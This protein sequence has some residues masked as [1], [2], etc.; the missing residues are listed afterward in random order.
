MY[1]HQLSYTL[2]ATSVSVK[3]ITSTGRHPASTLYTTPIQ[4]APSWS[5]IEVLTMLIRTKEV[6]ASTSRATR[7]RN[8]SSG[9]MPTSPIRLLASTRALVRNSVGARR[10]DSFCSS[11]PE[12]S[13]EPF[14]GYDPAA[15]HCGAIFAT[16]CSV[17]LDVESAIF[18]GGTSNQSPAA[19][20]IS[21]TATAATTPQEQP[22]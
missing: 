7:S 17:I 11:L 8:M 6:A 10:R 13:R 9:M 18:D 20:R 12:V 14:S 4:C 16:R 22:I 2:G 3:S 1:S 21:F 5:H 15:A 19:R